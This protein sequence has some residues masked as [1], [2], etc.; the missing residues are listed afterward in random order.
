MN[1]V[2]VEMAERLI[3]MD[4]KLAY[5]MRFVMWPVEQPEEHMRETWWKANRHD[6]VLLVENVRT[7]P[8]EILPGYVSN[9]VVADFDYGIWGTHKVYLVV[10]SY[11][12]TVR[13]F[14]E[15]YKGTQEYGAFFHQ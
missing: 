10:G 15:T 14:G 2:T 8:V 13:Y 4:S 7:E 11:I 3:S 5:N 12:D 1:I 6:L 9:R